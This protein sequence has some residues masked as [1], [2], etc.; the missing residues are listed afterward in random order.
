MAQH[1]QQLSYSLTQSV[2]FIFARFDLHSF[3]GILFI[4]VGVRSRRW[5]FVRCAPSG[6]I[7]LHANSKY[8]VF[9]ATNQT[10]D[11]HTH[12]PFLLFV[13]NQVSTGS[14][15]QTILNMFF[16]QLFGARLHVC[17]V[18]V[19]TPT[20]THASRITHSRQPGDWCCM[21]FRRTKTKKYNVLHNWPFQF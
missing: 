21:I 2:S 19:G 8:S 18:C 11:T 10:P 17:W 20:H 9:S 12:T 13:A 15:P 4:A 6:R 7:N 3:D 5:E 14:K 1:S 16:S